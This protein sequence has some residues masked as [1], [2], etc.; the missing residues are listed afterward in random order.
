MRKITVFLWA[1]IFALFCS[2]SWAKSCE[3]PVGTMN[4]AGLKI[5]Q[6]IREFQQHH[7]TAKTVILGGDNYQFEFAQ[8]VDTQIKK[9]GVSWVQH[10]RYDPHS[11]MIISYSL[12]FLDGPLA[13]YETD[14]D[15]FK[16][17]VLKRFQVAQNG[18][19]QAENKYVYQC[20]DYRIEIYQDH[21]VGHTAIGPTV[22]VFSKKSDAY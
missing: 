17:R 21:G 6:H 14:L 2:I 10:I 7:P 3:V 13:T 20:D 19:K 4:V 16:S 12:S 9:A 5:G 8:G 18:W 22:M 15:V 11:K 1:H